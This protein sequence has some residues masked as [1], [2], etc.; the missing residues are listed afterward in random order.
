[1]NIFKKFTKNL[2]ILL[3]AIILAVAIWI[4]AVTTTD[5]VE[6]RNYGRPVEL[7][8][9]GL[10]PSLIITTSLPEQVS[11][12]LSAP[13]S[14]WTNEL[15]NANVIRAVVDLSGLEAGKY[16]VPVSLQIDAQPV[17][18]E[19]YTPRVLDITLENLESAD[20]DITVMLSSSPA[21]GYEAGTPELSTSTA[22][23]SGPSSAVESV[24][25]VRATLDINQANEDIDMDLDLQALDDNGVVITEVAVSPE[26]INVTMPITQR[27][28]YRIVSVKPIKTG[29]VADGYQLTS[30]SSD[31]PV[32]TV[33]SANPELVNNL[34]GYIETQQFNVTGAKEDLQLSIPLDVPS[35][36]TVVGESTVQVT[37]SVSPIEGSKTLVDL[38]VEVVGL[39]P[40]YEITLSPDSVDVILTGPIP[41]LEDLTA[42]D[43][44]VLIDL[45]DYTAGTYQ[46]EPLVELDVQEILVESKLPA[47]IEVGITSPLEAS[48]TPSEN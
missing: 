43:I 15:S 36:I 41:T 42:E 30:I 4:L 24:T 21:I 46:I 28:G 10:D 3:T 33:Y 18:V 37:V 22:T 39:N 47:S 29:N 34:P 44:R 32:V 16:A 6:K 8:I 20:F 11:M 35:G 13:S 48:A 2:P 31:P 9:A 5:P 19:A 26:R 23:I 14:I 1:M 25:E 45:T 12:T 40:E 27:G 7:E 38:P 17:K